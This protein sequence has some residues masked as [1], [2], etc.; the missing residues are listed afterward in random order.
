MGPTIGLDHGA[1]NAGWEASAFSAT[2][3]K[4]YRVHSAS[5]LEPAPS[6]EPSES[7]FEERTYLL[8][9]PRVGWP[10]STRQ[11]IAVP[12]GGASL[13]IAWD[14]YAGSEQTVE[15]ALFGAFAGVGVAKNEERPCGWHATPYASV[16]LGFRG[17]EFYL[18]PKVGITGV[19]TFCLDLGF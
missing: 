5:E 1:L 9:E 16:A 4:S 10:Y 12:G 15:H 6:N 3:G 2:A 14:R 7:G 11:T 18:T 19:P 17:G 8:W 13:G